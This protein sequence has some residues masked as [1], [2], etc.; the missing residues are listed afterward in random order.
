MKKFKFLLLMLFVPFVFVSADE[1]NEL[2]IVNKFGFNENEAV[3]EGSNVFVGED[4]KSKNIV[5]GI[6]MLFG[7]NITFDGVDDYSIIGGNNLNIN[8]TINNDALIIGNVINFDTS[9]KMGRDLFVFGSTV[10]I[11]GEINRDIKIYA[12][13]VIIEDANISGSVTIYASNVKVADTVSIGGEFSLS[14]NAE[15]TVS[16]NIENI[17]FIKTYHKT[18]KD[19]VYSFL[20]D[21]AE[22]LFLFL[23]VAFIFPMLF[24]KINEK[25]TTLN[26]LIF[27]FGIGII[28]LFSIPVL[29]IML[30]TMLIGNSVA[31]TLL[32]LY[33]ALVC[34][35]TI[36]FGYLVGCYIN[37]TVFKKD[38]IFLSGFIG[39]TVIKLLS[40]I[41]TLDSII[42][43]LSL[44]L[45]FGIF[46]RLIR[47]ESH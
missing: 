16:S 33:I 37:K 21:Y 46:A 19:K 3:I 9:F 34:I 30:F 5:K 8:G 7:N 13:S 4:V 12:S 15:Y 32:M 27:D 44:I 1:T 41:P 20:K 35:T 38:N 47:K 23:I 25:Y 11:R 26:N 43:L 22:V 36:L 10:T 17:K 40:L 29:I 14:D 31:L 39:I 24:K 6:N 28:V 45:G 42:P 2:N 18:F